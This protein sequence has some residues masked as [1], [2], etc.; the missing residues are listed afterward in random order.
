MNVLPDVHTKNHIHPIISHLTSAGMFCHNHSVKV[1]RNEKYIITEGLRSHTCDLSTEW[2]SSLT[3]KVQSSKTEYYLQSKQ[4]H[5]T[6]HHLIVKTYLQTHDHTRRMIDIFMERSWLAGNTKRNISY[7]SILP[8]DY[9][10][11]TNWIAQRKPNESPTR[12][13]WNV[14][15]GSWTVE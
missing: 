13:S 15:P 14:P 2:H 8:R 10:D 12:H 11:R 3:L 4:L 6:G 1:T 7:A 5:S 9:Q